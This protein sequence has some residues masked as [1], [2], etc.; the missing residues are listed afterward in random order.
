MDHTISPWNAPLSAEDMRA[1]I[2]N[3]ES[4]SDVDRSHVAPNAYWETKVWF[5]ADGGNKELQN[6]PKSRPLPPRNAP[7]H[8]EN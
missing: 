7:F 8:P 2:S 1:I 5:K 4:L 3:Y 6:R